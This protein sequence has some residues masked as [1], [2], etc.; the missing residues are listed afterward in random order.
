MSSSASP[1]RSRKN[2]EDIASKQDRQQDRNAQ[3]APATPRGSPQGQHRACDA[4]HRSQPEPQRERPLYADCGASNRKIE[5]K[6]K[7][8]AGITASTASVP[9]T[10][11]IGRTAEFGF[12]CSPI[13]IFRSPQLR[14]YLPPKVQAA[15]TFVNRTVGSQTA[16]KL[17]P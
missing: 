16:Y 6:A 15:V 1:P 13:M 17:R 5:K 4:R 8:A 7:N 2:C 14:A 3:Q 12:T 11:A 9:I 10:A